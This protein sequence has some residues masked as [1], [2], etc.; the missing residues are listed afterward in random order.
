MFPLDVDFLLD[1]KICKLKRSQGGRAIAVWISLLC[2]IYGSGGYFL[3]WDKDLPF[4]ISEELPG[5]NASF[6]Q[7]VIRSCLNFGL[8]DKEL[9]ERKEILSSAAIQSRFLRL[10]RN[11]N[12]DDIPVDFRIAPVSEH[13]FDSFNAPPKLDFPREETPLPGIDYAEPPSPAQEKFCDVF[14]ERAGQDNAW[15]AS[16]AQ[17]MRIGSD[18]E[19]RLLFNSFR[20]EQ[21]AIGKKHTID[22]KRH[23]LSWLKIRRAKESAGHND[24][25]ALCRKVNCDD[26][27]YEGSF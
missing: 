6:V 25:R 17:Y 9:F 26:K 27:D 4:I 13:P 11:L 23:F 7:E 12:P 2:R 1:L 19:I 15:F 21:Y 20:N 18:A 5:I 16:V 10:C 24:S 8:L 3:K 14:L 22:A